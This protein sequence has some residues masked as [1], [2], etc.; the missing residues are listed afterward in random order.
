MSNYISHSSKDISEKDVNFGGV[1]ESKLQAP[2]AI[3]A[4]V[5]SAFISSIGQTLV[6]DDV[7]TDVGGGYNP[8]TG[9]F[10]APV[11]GLYVFSITVMVQMSSSAAIALFVLKKNDDAVMWLYVNENYTVTEMASGTGLLSLK[12]GDTVRVTSDPSGRHIYGSYT[13]FS[14]FKL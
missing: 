6:F 11:D 10:N 5:S 13:F 3:F 4:R 1:S 9:V 7:F 8:G 2:V 14:G 12:V